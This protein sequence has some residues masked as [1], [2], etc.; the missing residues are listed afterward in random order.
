M[1][2]VLI[3]DEKE[4]LYPNGSANVMP[5]VVYITV[6]GIQLKPEEVKRE[7]GGVRSY[8]STLL[9]RAVTYLGEL[10]L[11]QVFDVRKGG[12]YT[13]G[14]PDYLF[15]NVKVT[16]FFPV[17]REVDGWLRLARTRPGPDY[18]LLSDLYPSLP[19]ANRWPRLFKAMKL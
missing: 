7:G 16:A 12:S 8:K 9:V 6:A 11:D 4:P 15:V 2:V 3:V 5:F 14:D 17:D 18:G 10:S 1:S 19:E 13:L